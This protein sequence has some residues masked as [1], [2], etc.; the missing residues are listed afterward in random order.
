LSDREQ[1][2]L[3][4]KSLVQPKAEEQ[5]KILL[6]KEIYREVSENYNGFAAN[7]GRL[8]PLP[9]CVE[10]FLK[11]GRPEPCSEDMGFT[12]NAIRVLMSRYIARNEIGRM[13]ETPS[14]VFK[15]VVLGFQGLTDTSRLE[16]I[17]LS[18]RFVFNSPTLFNMFA[19]GARGTLSA[20]YV[21]PVYDDMRSIMDATVVQ[22]VTFKYGGGQGFSFSNLRPRWSVIKGTGSYSS[23]P[24]SLM[25]IFDAVTDSV[26]QG[27]KRRGANMGVMHVWHPDIYNPYF[28]PMAA[29][30]AA[31]PLPEKIIHSRVKNILIKAREAGITVDENLLKIISETNEISPEE[32]GFIQ[33]KEG[34]LGDVFL[35]NFNISVGVN[36]A[37]M[38]A[39]VENTEWT[40][41][42]PTVTGTVTGEGD[43]RIH[44]SFTN[45]TGLGRLGEEYGKHEW[46]KRNPY[47]N[48]FEEVIGEAEQKAKDI[49]EKAGYK[50]N[51][52]NPYIWKHPARKIFEK[53]VENAWKSGDP[54]LL[55]LDNHNKWSPTPWLGIV[56]ATNP[57]VSGGTRILTPKGWV[58]AREIF[59]EAKTGNVKVAVLADGG[60][61]GENGIPEAYETMLL[62]P[63]KDTVVHRTV[64]GR[65]LLLKD[66]T[67]VKAWTWYLGRKQGLRVKTREGFEITVTPDHKLLTTDGWKEAK[68]LKPGDKIMIAR[69]NP[70]SI[71]HTSGGIRLDEDVAFAIGW[72]LGDGTLNKYYVAWYFGTDDIEAMEKVKRAIV[73]LGGNLDIKPV[74]RNNETILSYGADTT[75]YKRI[76]RLVGNM[77]NS[78]SRRIPELVWK[79]HP[80]SLRHILRGLFT[81]DGTVDADKEIRLTSPSREM[82][83]EIQL[84]LLSLGITS[85]IYE[86]PYEKEFHYTTKTGEEKVY[87]SKGYYELVISGCSRR[88]FAELI[89]FESA[90][91]LSKLSFKNTKIDSVWATVEEVEDAGLVDFYD[92]TV[93]GFHT[94]IANGF[95]HHN[96]GEQPL[97][98]F[99]SCNLGSVSVEKYL[100]ENGL[101]DINKYYDDIRVIVDA[102]DAVIDANKH[103]DERQDEANKFTRK[104]GLGIMGLADLLAK[105]N[106]PYDSD[107]AVA[108][109]MILMAG[110][111][112]YSWKRSWELGKIRGP[113]PAFACRIWDWRQMKCLEEGD[114]TELLDLHTPGLLKQK[115]V[116][117]DTN[118]WVMV[119][120]HDIQLPDD[121]VVRLMGETKNR[122]GRDG[123][124]RLIPTETLEKIAKKVFGITRRHVDEALRMKP[125]QV[126]ES[127]KH[128][129][130]LAVFNPPTAWSILRR[131]GES[132]GAVAPR[133]TVTTTIAPT[134]TISILAGTSSGIEP[135]FALVFRRKVAVGEFLEVV[136]EFRN[137]LLKIIEEHGLPKEVVNEIFEVIS[138]NKGSIR[139]SINRVKEI[140]GKHYNASD[141]EKLLGEIEKLAEIFPMSMDFDEWFH[142][143]HQIAAQLYVDQSISKTINLPKNAPLDAVYTAYFTAW[144]GGL[145]GVTIYRD[146]SKA[147]QVIYFGETQADKECCGG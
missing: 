112:A 15:R 138:K 49:A 71:G 58:T 20:C 78:R 62:V 57:C 31:L 128:L 59:E 44:Y 114:P 108:V 100:G 144:L 24:L 33:A 42:T 73:K 124:L 85:R 125:E 29:Y 101:F 83:Q 127:P 65:E 21:T 3:I 132:I 12:Y 74:V 109:T 39:V 70:H 88:L 46:M 32:A 106:I 118:G 66:V 69:I 68:D 81:A 5:A 72:L 55:F 116:R 18:R 122:I 28:D 56:V 98:P 10:A 19:D 7:G 84:L 38:K 111:A 9:E 1:L 102:M 136:R 139:W 135:Y 91:K 77:S 54:G 80:T 63:F 16:E 142:L 99:E 45:A 26:K 47:I 141:S 60:V 90:R 67:P 133:N 110:L 8:T 34:L 14:M 130:A 53:I 134:G 6:L 82:L 52:K 36:D 30:K 146:E 107:D 11:G 92:F 51:D 126:A 4:K 22:A 41:I 105:L 129:L 87:K 145:K 93:P 115:Y 104:I 76:H 117:K 147:Q 143:A 95:V 2:I 61:L 89:G 119:K 121:V 86:R 40:M 35:T 25:R 140:V 64:R 96:C 27:G 23:G 131:Y 43:Y 48:R 137:R 123:S 97:Y 50:V 79:T 17:L 113:A 13:V 75:L 103:P 120:Y 94:Y 37:F